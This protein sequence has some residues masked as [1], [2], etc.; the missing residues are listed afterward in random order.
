MTM[1]ELWFISLCAPPA[2]PHLLKMVT[3]WWLTSIIAKTIESH[4]SEIFW[5][6]DLLKINLLEVIGVEVGAAWEVGSVVT[7]SSEHNGMSQ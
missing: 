2:P 6:L 5:Q 4:L 7:D 1:A 3:Y